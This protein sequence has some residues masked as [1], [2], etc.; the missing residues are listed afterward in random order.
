MN[1]ALPVV[2]SDGVGTAPDLVRGGENGFVFAQGDVEALA[3]C[4]AK[5][6]KDR[7]SAQSMGRRSLEIVSQWSFEEDVKGILAALKHVSRSRA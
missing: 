5:L 4:L 1:F 3:Q 2:V 7:R 6:L